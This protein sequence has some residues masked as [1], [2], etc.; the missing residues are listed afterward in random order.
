MTYTVEH[1]FD[2]TKIVILDDTDTLSDVTIYIDED[3]VTLLQLDYIEHFAVDNQVTLSM[4]MVKELI[5]AYNSV[6]GVYGSKIL[7]TP[8]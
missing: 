2:E 6:E 1:E 3:Q 7:L 4:T 8:S 5:R